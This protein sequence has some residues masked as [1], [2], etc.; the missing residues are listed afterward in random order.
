[1]RSPVFVLLQMPIG[2][3]GPLPG[4]KCPVGSRPMTLPAITEPAVET[5]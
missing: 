2:G 4:T 5:R 1:M 3:F